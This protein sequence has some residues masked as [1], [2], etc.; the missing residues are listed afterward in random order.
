VL[1]P[2]DEKKFLV[3]VQHKYGLPCSQWAAIT[4]CAMEDGGEA[5]DDAVG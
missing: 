2:K 1:T 4:L 5:R 3:F